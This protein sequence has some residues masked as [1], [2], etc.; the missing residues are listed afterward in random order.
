M[1]YIPNSDFTMFWFQTI[2]GFFCLDFCCVLHTGLYI[3]RTLCNFLVCLFESKNGSI[4]APKGD[5]VKVKQKFSQVKYLISQIFSWFIN[6]Y[7]SCVQLF[8]P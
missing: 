1:F 4:Q 5:P 6:I 3:Y 2:S 8:G 7:L